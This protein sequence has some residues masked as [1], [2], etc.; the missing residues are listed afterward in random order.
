MYRQIVLHP[1]DRRLV[2]IFFRF[3]P[4]SPIELYELNTVTNVWHWYGKIVYGTLLQ[5]AEDERADFPLALPALRHNFYVD[6][7][8]GGA[9]SVSEARELRQQL[10]EL[11][12][13]GGFELRKW[14]SNCLGVLSGLPAEHIGTQLSLHFEST[15][16]ME[17]PNLTMR[18]ILSNIARIHHTRKIANAGVVAAENRMG[19]FG[20]CTHLQQMEIGYE[21]SSEIQLLK[22]GEMLPYQFK[23]S[24]L[25]PKNHQLDHL[26]AVHIHEKLMHGGGRLLL[27]RIREEYWPLDGRQLVKNVV[28]NCFRCI[29]QDPQLTQQQTGQ[30][31]YER[32]TPSRPFSI[33]GVDYAGP[34]YLKQ[35]HKKDAAAK[36]Y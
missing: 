25:L 6:V 32:I 16:I 31:P 19:R 33:T 22:K 10:S 15:A 20:P 13:K 8:I 35:A 21:F 30:L 4:Q 1:D 24:I 7:F 17:T 3:S 9:N 2:R 12:S 23:H 28:R 18:S 11:L 27:S 29:R 26:I 14:T 36:C 34:L 5:L